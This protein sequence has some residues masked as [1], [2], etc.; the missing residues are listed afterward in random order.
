M[1]SQKKERGTVDTV[2]P[3]RPP[4]LPCYELKSF[5]KVTNSFLENVIK[6]LPGRFCNPGKGGGGAWWATMLVGCSGWRWGLGR[7][8]IIPQEGPD[9]GAE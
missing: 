5:M 6:N 2:R 4:F 3:R 8:D 1:V 7:A 9:G